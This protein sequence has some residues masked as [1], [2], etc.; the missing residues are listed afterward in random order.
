ML[1]S[2]GYFWPGFLDTL[3]LFCFCLC[4]FTLALAS[5]A[6]SASAAIA[7]C[8]CCGKRTS[9]LKYIEYHQDEGR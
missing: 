1:T 9:L 4:F 7:L 3:D 8:N 6:A 5:L 2:S